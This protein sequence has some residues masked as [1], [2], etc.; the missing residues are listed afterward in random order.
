MSDIN[1]KFY[2]DQIKE[3]IKLVKQN[4]DNIKHLVERINNL[5][6]NNYSTKLVNEMAEFVLN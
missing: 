3:L 4:Q 5:E 2:K 6:N 1:Y